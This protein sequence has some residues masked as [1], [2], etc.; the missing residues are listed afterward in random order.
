MIFIKLA[1]ILI[2]VK[3]MYLVYN[4]FDY[5]NPEKMILQ[6]KVKQLFD[7][8]ERVNGRDKKLKLYLK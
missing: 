1:Y 3:I 4:K 2:V 7:K 8:N 6:L 5:S